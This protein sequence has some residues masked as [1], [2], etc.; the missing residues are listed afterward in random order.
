MAKHGQAEASV[1]DDIN[2]G[3]SHRA[4]EVVWSQVDLR[5]YRAKGTERHGWRE[6]S[7]K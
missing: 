7:A 3:D 4:S 1:V 6:S 5:W 2:L